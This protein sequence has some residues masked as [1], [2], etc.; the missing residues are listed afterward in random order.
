MQE[1]I[2]NLRLLCSPAKTPR[3][4]F[5]GQM[6]VSGTFPGANPETSHMIPAY[7]HGYAVRALLESLIHA[8]VGNVRFWHKADVWPEFS[9]GLNTDHECWS[10]HFNCWLPFDPGERASRRLRSEGRD[11]R[12]LGAGS[13]LLTVRGMFIKAFSDECG[14]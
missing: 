5:C 7:L 11:F 8:D 4:R 9:S 6:G 2:F 10:R 14:T 12:G 1:S 3:A 13:L